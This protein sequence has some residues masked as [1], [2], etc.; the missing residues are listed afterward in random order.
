LGAHVIGSV[1]HES[2][3]A[4]AEANGAEYVV[5]TSDPHWP[6]Q[7]RDFTDGVGVRV[8]YDGIGKDTFEGS[9]ATLRKLGM[10]V[11]YGSASGPV[12]PFSP[13]LLSAGGSLFLTRPTLW[14]Y[15]ETR[16]KLMESAAALFDML[17][18]G[19][20]RATIA[21]TFPLAEAAEAH[22]AIESRAVTGSIVLLP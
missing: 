12:A 19:E 6:A 3:V 4:V 14:D 22:R 5:V 16:G 2:K 10:M 15:V 1:G 18:R 21:R 8:V 17:H 7:V 11:S 13:A 20:V 9:L